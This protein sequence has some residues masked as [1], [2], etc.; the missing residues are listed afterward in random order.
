MKTIFVVLVHG[1]DDQP[2]Q[3]NIARTSVEAAKI[4]ARITAQTLRDGDDDL[5]LRESVDGMTFYVEHDEDT[6]AIVE[7]QSAWLE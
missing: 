7:V 3:A 1:Q 4:M 5:S 6:V 2:P